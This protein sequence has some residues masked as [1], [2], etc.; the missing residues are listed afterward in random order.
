SQTGAAANTVVHVHGGH[1]PPDVDGYPTATIAPG[2]QTT[3]YYPNTQQA[4]TLWYHDHAMG[5]TDLNLMMGLAGFYLIRD[6]VENALQLPSGSFETPLLIQ[7]RTFNPDGTL[8]YQLTGDRF[9]GDKIL[10]NGKV[11]P[12]LNV[13]RGKYRFR[14]LNGSNS[15]FYALSLASSVAVQPFWIIGTDGG[16]L[17]KPVAV[18]PPAS[19]NH[20]TSRGLARADRADVVIFFS[21]SPVGTEFFLR[22]S[23]PAPTDESKVM[24]F[25]VVNGAASSGPL[26]ATLRS[27][28]RRDPTT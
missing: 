4:T 7:D 19:A 21:S 22:K 27:F 1:N 23:E 26:P 25:L 9:F 20:R 11:W 5:I 16:L 24:K 10:V 3:Y 15:R 8:K 28:P 2:E 18:Y 6:P 17:P 13:T 12:K 14:L